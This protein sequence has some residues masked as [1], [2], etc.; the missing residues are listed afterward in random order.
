MTSFFG[1][2]SRYDVIFRTS[3]PIPFGKCGKCETVT[4]LTQTWESAV[5]AVSPWI[6]VHHTDKV[7][8]GLMVKFFGLVFFRWPPTGN[9]S[10]DALEHKA[11]MLAYVTHA[12]Y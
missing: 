1:Q 3:V 7:E 9:F 6:F 4:I 2:V 10:A 8:G 5:G 11:D 12:H